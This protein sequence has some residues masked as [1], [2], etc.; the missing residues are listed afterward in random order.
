MIGPIGVAVDTRGSV[1]V[2][3]VG[4]HRVQKFDPQG[5]VLLLWGGH[6]RNQGQFSFPEGIA[7]LGD[8]VYVSDTLNHRIQKFTTSGAFLA[9]W[10]GFGTQN[11]FSMLPCEWVAG[12]SSS[13]PA[14][15]QR[16]A[17]H[18]LGDREFQDCIGV[19]ANAQGEVYVVDAGKHRLL[20]FD[21]EGRL[22]TQ[23]GRYGS[24]PGQFWTPLGVEVDREGAV[25]VADS[26][27]HRIQKFKTDGTFFT[28]FGNFGSDPG[29]LNLPMD[30]AVSSDG[31]VY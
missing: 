13:P 9:Q 15:V 2:V 14:L 23:W 21:K 5:K 19:A 12:H 8:I 25:Y 30:L 3:E 10:Q 1:Y 4:N 20:K 27:N 29:G 17:S 26:G 24:G 22:L 11:L 7:I 16:V 28:E 6:G 18:S 31:K